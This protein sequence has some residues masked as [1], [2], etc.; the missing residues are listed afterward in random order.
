ME[1]Q[2]ATDLSNQPIPDV[3]FTMEDLAQHKGENDLPI[4]IGCNGLIFQVSEEKREMYAPGAGYSVFAGTDATRALAKS[5]LNA[6]DLQPYGSLEG[7]TEK[8]LKTLKQWEDFYK[9]RYVIVGK[10]KL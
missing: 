8:E 9:K 7:L 3:Y 6:E 4:W 2:Q 10:I 5:S 1:Q